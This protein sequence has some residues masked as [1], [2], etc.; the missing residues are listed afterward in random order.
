MFKIDY[1]VPDILIPIVEYQVFH[2]ETKELLDL[3][4]WKDTNI[5]ISYPI[6]KDIE[7]NN[8]F[9]HDPSDKF[10]NDKC[11]SYNENGT[12]IILND[13]KKKL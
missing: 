11:Y 13:R 7:S 3:N 8:I 5:A 6:L 9:I 1:I 12:D 2:P 4:I 10:Y